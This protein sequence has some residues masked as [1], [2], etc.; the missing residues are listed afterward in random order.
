MALALEAVP[1]VARLLPALEGLPACHL[2]GGAVRDLLR[3]ATPTD[4]DLCVDADALPVAVE[5]AA[6]LHGEATVHEGFS[7]ATV[8]APG[9]QF[10]LARTRRERYERPGALPT[11]EPAP[12]LEDLGRRDFT[13]NAMAL[14]LASEERGRLRDP[15]GGRADLTAS[16]VRVLHPRSFIDDPTRL[17]RAVR[18]ESRLGARMDPGT[19]ALVH[20]AVDG[21]ALGTVSGARVRDE[22]L[23]LLAELGLDRALH[24]ALDADP[25]LV[26]RAADH[27]GELGADPVLSGLA[28]LVSSGP[29]A[30]GRWLDT[31][32]LPRHARDAVLRAARAAP[33]LVAELHD[34]RPAS[35]LYELLR[36][37]PLETLALALAMGADEDLVGRYV[38]E[39]SAVTLEIT[40]HDLVAAGVPPSPRLGEALRAT[41]RRKLDGELSGREHELRAALELAGEPQS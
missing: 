20:R 29:N 6:R 38:V 7:T 21:S 31:L 23:D 1:G 33:R 39:L 25:G 2:V 5:L 10:D 22:L 4:L 41:L 13:V 28:A 14:A 35:A 8:R 36:P 24:P 9:V 11:V 12:L 15:H 37:E 32:A 40:G 26:A 18:Y 27:A 30:L 16:T 19:E 3:D 34:Q 17:L